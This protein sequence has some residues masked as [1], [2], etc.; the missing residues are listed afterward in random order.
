M[1]NPIDRL[2]ELGAD[3]W[4]DPVEAAL[5]LAEGLL[6]VQ[7]AA[8]P[9]ALEFVS[10]L[11]RTRADHPLL[12]SVTEAALDPDASRAKLEVSNV[13]D[14]LEDDTWVADLARSLLALDSLGV[15]S[16]G[17]TTLELLEVGLRLGATWQVLQTDQRAIG[18]GVGYLQIPVR[19]KPAEQAQAMLVPGAA[20]FGSRLWTTRQQADR[21][22]RAKPAGTEVVTVVH[23]LAHLSPL[24]R[25]AYR[26]PA[27]LMD[28]KH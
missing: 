11:R 2:R 24:N 21:I 14:R 12:L 4:V 17:S 15:T 1:T 8:W 9:S 13:A 18:Q 10:D 27:I 23:P 16:I 7:D 20:R 25:L 19:P 3:D 5:A 6:A 28:F 26:P 22:A